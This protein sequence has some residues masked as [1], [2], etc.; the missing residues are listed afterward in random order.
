MGNGVQLPSLWSPGIEDPVTDAVRLQE[1]VHVL[2]ALCEFIP[3]KGLESRAN[4]Q[5]MFPEPPILGEEFIV[6]G[7][8][9]GVVLEKAYMA[10][11]C[12]G[13]HQT[14]LT[15]S[16]GAAGRNHVV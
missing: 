2:L 8:R 13:W 3:T 5:P 7:V 6:A 12:C 4:M 9:W 16:A 11:G 14:Q 10:L 1:A 15:S